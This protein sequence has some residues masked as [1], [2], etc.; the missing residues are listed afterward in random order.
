MPYSITSYADNLIWVVIEGHL[1]VHHAE[2]YYSDMWTLLNDMH[3]PVDLLVDGRHIAGAAPG[4]RRRT[5]QIVQHPHLGYL[6]FVVN[7]HHLLL[8]APLVK[9]VSGIGLFGDT[10]DAL[11]YLRNSRGL[12]LDQ[13]PTLVHTAD[14]LLHHEV[15]EPVFARSAPL[16]TF[17]PNIAEQPP[18]S[19]PRPAPRPL[20]QPIPR[21][22][23][24]GAETIPNWPLP[25]PPAS[26]Q[27]QTPLFPGHP[28]YDFDPDDWD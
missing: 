4:A 18:L 6:A 7:E 17:V 10:N 15:A 20:L 24:V 9:L 5:E 1:A 21:Q 26:R 13:E 16:P 3:A 2:S 19:I 12:P 22:L 27:K 28:F 11:C 14:V 8:F 23:A 25:P